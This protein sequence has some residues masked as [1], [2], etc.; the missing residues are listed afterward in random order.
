MSLIIMMNESSAPEA[1]LFA[2]Q[3]FRQKIIHDIHT[4]DD[5][6]KF[7][8]QN[9]ILELLYKLR[10]GPKNIITQLVMSLANLSV[11][12]ADKTDV[13]STLLNSYQQEEE[14]L[15]C[16]LEFLTVLPEE[17]HDIGLNNDQVNSIG[18]KL[19][20]NN[21]QL[22][23]NLILNLKQ[24]EEMSLDLQESMLKC[25]YSWL[26]SGDIPLSSIYSTNLFRDSFE[27]L[28]TEALFDVGCDLICEIIYASSLNNTT[29]D[30]GIVERINH[31]LTNLTLLLS[32]SVDDP[33]KTRALSRV[34]VE[35]GEAYVHLLI[36]YPE[37]FTNIMQGIL[38]CSDYEDLDVV[39]ITFHFW[40]TLTDELLLKYA[41]SSIPTCFQ[42][43]YLQLLQMILK[44]L[45]YP[46]DL[47]DWTSTEKDDFREFRYA[48]GSVLKDCI[49]ILKEV[50]ALSVPW[51]M[52]SARMSLGNPNDWQSIEAPLFS[53]RQMCSQVSSKENHI[54][55][56]IM[57]LL[58]QLPQH[59]KIRYAVILV[60]GRYAEWTNE[61]PEY[62]QYQLQY[63]SMG[64][65][66]PE[67]VAA[68]AQTLKDLCKYCSCHLKDY[69][70]Q[71]HSF[72]MN[73]MSSLPLEDKKQVMEAV[74]HVISVV[75]FENILGFIQSFC[76][77]IIQ[78]LA[79]LAE[80]S[81][82]E[83]ETS[84][85]KES[86]E[87]LD[88]FGVY[89]KHLI[90]KSIPQGHSH[91][92]VTVLKET[93]PVLKLILLGNVR[94]EK[95]AENGARFMRSCI[96]AYRYHMMELV[97]EWAETLSTL[98]EGSGMGCWCWV[99]CK[100]VYYYGQAQKESSPIAHALV[101]RM[102]NHVFKLCQSKPLQV[103]DEGIY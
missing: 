42:Q 83:L 18:V 58:P 36:E 57:Q 20:A 52:L 23:L 90:P 95:I 35:A 87:L 22:V 91:P 17:L 45:H 101:E 98:F 40:H 71:L 69:L 93:W 60:M 54:L 41:S 50:E 77:P 34:F 89:L 53:I 82:T 66:E 67:N 103:L 13:V 64:F 32:T 8:L 74:A 16:I 48:I 61:H 1:K 37:S 33:L 47:E 99:S 25:L 12:L 85:I 78:R 79:L 38:I 100:F 27:A 29:M 51:N 94:I 15:S 44:H 9:S 56:Q 68:S 80:K 6:F 31:E 24:Q 63:V 5:E 11:L 70:P 2:A 49:C 75:D 84:E 59:P 62:I 97:P 81:K 102:T 43:A 72:Y 10:N 4:V 76:L 28:K 19:L 14:M 55:P 30:K 92:C 39:P 3:T 26:R 7:N 88:M 96:L 46:T 65:E 86:A 73:I 21:A